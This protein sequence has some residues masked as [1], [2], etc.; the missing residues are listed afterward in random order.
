MLRSNPL[1]RERSER[2]PAGPPGSP[3]FNPGG[4]KAWLGESSGLMHEGDRRASSPR[5]RLRTAP[6]P[7]LKHRPGRCVIG[8]AES[9]VDRQLGLPPGGHHLRLHSPPRSLA[10]S[11]SAWACPSHKENLELTYAGAWSDPGDGFGGWAQYPITGSGLTRW[12]HESDDRA[13]WDRPD[14]H[15][16]VR[17]GRRL[18]PHERMRLCRSSEAAFTEDS[19]M[20]SPL[21]WRVRSMMILVAVV[22]VAIAAERGRRHWAYCRE[23]A[24]HWDTACRVLLSQA[25]ELDRE[26]VRYSEWAS[27]GT[28]LRGS[29][30]SWS[31]RATAARN[32]AEHHRWLAGWDG[33]RARHYRRAAVRPWEVLAPEPTPTP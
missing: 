13:T 17:Y 15:R 18:V 11:P 21:I 25:N 1:R 30:T 4:P 8:L 7:E 9:P 32:S 19:M 16:R 14:Q 23:Q 20:R 27:R 22:A 33:R 3:T 10:A 5:S 12:R 2:R 26:A 24:Q 28:P 6:S 31:E 29:T